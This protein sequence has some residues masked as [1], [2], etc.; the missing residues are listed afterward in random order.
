MPEVEIKWLR[1]KCGKPQ[2]CG[3]CLEVCPHAVFVMFAVDREMG[4]ISEKYEIVPSYDSFCTLCNL[5]VENC[6]KDAL[7]IKIK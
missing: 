7:E 6:P 3:K 4:K 5:C 2:K 1:E